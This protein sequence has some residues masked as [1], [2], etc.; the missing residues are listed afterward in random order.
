VGDVW[1]PKESAYRTKNGAGQ[2]SLRLE[3]RR[4]ARDDV[5]ISKSSQG[6]LPEYRLRRKT[7]VGRGQQGAES[8]N[9]VQEEEGTNL[10]PTRDLSVLL[11]EEGGDRVQTRGKYTR[12][13]LGGKRR[14]KKPKETGSN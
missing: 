9:P 13:G 5:W 6:T 8:E 10:P 14:V 3:K 1:K 7:G 4:E 12:G 11:S 2:K